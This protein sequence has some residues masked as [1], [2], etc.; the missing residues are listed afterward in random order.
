[1]DNLESNPKDVDF[2]LNVLEMF[3]GWLLTAKDQLA[4]KKNENEA[5][6][7][8]LEKTI[9]NYPSSTVYNF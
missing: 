9:G 2:F 8:E 6:L 3:R 1:M 4:V 7:N 5:A